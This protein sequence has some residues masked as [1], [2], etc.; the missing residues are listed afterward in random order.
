LN[1]DRW[2]YRVFQS[3]PVLIRALLACS[4][5]ALNPPGLDPSE[6]GD[7]LYRFQTLEIKELSHRLD[8][9]LWPRQ[10][11]GCA[12]IGSPE[13]QV[14]HL[15]VQMHPDPGFTT[16]WRH[17]PTAFCSNIPSLSTGRWW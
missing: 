16:A 14:V 13:F 1:T 3:A 6:P 9:V 15:E 7:R 12:E 11:T 8:G 10:T 4:A 2:Y 17:R 5:G